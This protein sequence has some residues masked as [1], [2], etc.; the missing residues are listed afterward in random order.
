MNGI[1]IKSALQLIDS[2]DYRDGKGNFSVIFMTCHRKKKTGGE[3]IRLDNACKCGLPPNCK[4]HE[5]RGIKDMETGKPYAV[6]NRLIFTLNQQE[7][8]WV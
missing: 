6:H 3:L 1:D 7:I 4:G 8:Y 2:K 5:M